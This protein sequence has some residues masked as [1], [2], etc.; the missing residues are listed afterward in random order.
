MYTTVYMMHS[1]FCHTVTDE[2]GAYI[3]R[4]GAVC[5]DVRVCVRVCVCPRAYAAELTRAAA[6]ERLVWS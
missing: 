4:D 5:I 3:C 2:D 6:S 1:L